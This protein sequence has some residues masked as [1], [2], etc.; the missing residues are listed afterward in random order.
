MYLNCV[1]NSIH[2][3]LTKELPKSTRTKIRKAVLK[4][5]LEADGFKDFSK[6]EKRLRCP[7]CGGKHIVRHGCR[8][9]DGNTRRYLCRECGKGFQVSPNAAVSNSKRGPAQWEPF[10]DAVLLGKTLKQCAEAAG[11]VVPTAC[12][13]RKRVRKVTDELLTN[14]ELQPI[15]QR[16]LSHKQKGET[17][18]ETMSIQS[19]QKMEGKE[20]VTNAFSA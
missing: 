5:I 4:S 8:G 9:K 18:G 3:D 10:I 14:G 16:N 13:W 1:S 12:N 2:F 20:E 19:L 15:V 17:K 7:N 11:I 6:M